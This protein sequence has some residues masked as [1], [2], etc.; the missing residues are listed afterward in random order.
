MIAPSLPSLLIEPVVRAALIEDFGRSGDLTSQAIIPA[1]R[2]AS[3]VIATRAPGRVAGLE[4]ARMAFHLVDPSLQVTSLVPDGAQ[5]EAG[6]VLMRI[7]GNARALLGAERVA[8]NFMS[9]L[10][11]IATHTALYVARV[12]HT[13][14]RIVDTRKTTPGL[15]LVEKYAVLCGGGQNHRFGLDDAILIKD[16]HIAIAGGIIPALRAAKAR[17]GH[18]VRIEIE[19]DTLDQLVEALTEGVDLVLL[20]NM[21]PPV[22]R[23]AVAM[24]DGRCTSEASGGVNLDSV[25]A[26]AEAG[27]DL[28]SIGGLTHSAPILDLG[29]DI[30]V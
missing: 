11:G 20:D 3:A 10:C 17:A 16:N 25:V 21:S 1:N 18:M 4:V 2:Q 13:R 5:V 23:Q 6:A 27:V 7:S 30:A 8:L 24:I 22:L 15:R 26:I 28:I 12:A 29:L 19:V 9:R 14:A